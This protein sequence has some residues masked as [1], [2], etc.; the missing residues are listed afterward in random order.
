MVRLAFALV[1]AF[2]L[3][4]VAAAQVSRIRREGQMC[5][6]IAG[7]Q[8]EK[9]LWCD[10]QPGLC[11]GADIAGICVADA[12]MCTLVYLP[13]CGCDG[14][15][16]GNDCERRRVKVAKDHDGECLK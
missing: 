8:C 9:G 7:F 1:L 11:R 6:G 13:V 4:D 16:Y 12:E 5:G 15:S 3:A 10:P 2:A 14:R